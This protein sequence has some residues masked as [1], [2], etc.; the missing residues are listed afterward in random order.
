MKCRRRKRERIMKLQKASSLIQFAIK[1]IPNYF[2]L[3]QP[4]IYF[5]K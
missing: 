5:S 2:D 1:I 3:V 4:L